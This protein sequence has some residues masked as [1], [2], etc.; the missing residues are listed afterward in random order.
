MYTQCP[1]C[2]VAFRVTANILQQA[3]GNVRCGNCSTAFSAITYLSETMPAVRP[4]DVQEKRSESESSRRLRESLDELTGPEDVRIEDTGIEWRV[5]SD[6]PEDDEDHGEA[7]AIDGEDGEDEDE[8]LPVISANEERRYDDNTPLP[9]GFIDRRRDGYSPP[10]VPGRRA[11]DQLQPSPDFAERQGDLALSEP[12]DWTELL[13]EVRDTDN[14]GDATGEDSCDAKP[15]GPGPLAGAD[16]DDAAEPLPDDADALSEGRLVMTDAEFDGPEDAL[17]DEVPLLADAESPAAADNGDEDES[18][19]DSAIEVIED[20]SYP[21]LEDTGVEEAREM[22][23]VTAGSERDDWDSTEEFEAQ[24][25]A[26]ALAF[27]ESSAEIGHGEDADNADDLADED[28]IA[29]DDVALLEEENPAAA[30]ESEPADNDEDERLAEFV[31]LP[32]TEEELSVNM[33]IDH[34]LMAAAVEDDKFSATLVGMEKPEWMFDENAAGVETIIMEGDFVRT[35]IDEERLAAENAV[36]SQLDDPD[37]LFDTYAS[38]RQKSRHG[39]RFSD[40]PPRVMIS[41]AAVLALLLVGQAIH[42]S[43]ES[44]A[45][46]GFFKQTLQPVYG[47]LGKDLMP[48]WDVGG[49]QFETTNGSVDDTDTTLTIVSRLQ[50]RSEGALPYPLLHVSLTDR[51]EEIIGSKVLKPAEYLAG[52]LNQDQLVDPG[53]TFTAVIAVSDAAAEATGFKL[54]VCYGAAAGRVRCALQDFKN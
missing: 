15:D 38:S 37:D 52:N 12:E 14:T 20:D 18:E 27:A 16:N 4:P 3:A 6:E 48:Y 24:I 22:G 23:E 19:A 1:E 13:D 5:L 31:V 7:G 54:N 34:E 25:N 11:A 41:V 36:R 30:A 9:D 21:A 28:D 50:N 35:A 32:A 46:V 53:E 49:W 42:Q 29:D 44:L 39:R 43:R 8:V 33:E 26:A 17:T 51:W 45:T 2:H 47:F 40:P 10:L